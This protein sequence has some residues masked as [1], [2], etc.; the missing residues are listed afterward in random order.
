MKVWIWFI[1]TIIVIGGIVGAYYVNYLTN[2][3]SI[4]TEEEAREFV[5]NVINTNENFSDLKNRGDFELSLEGGNWTA[6]WG[7]GGSFGCVVIFDK[8]GNLHED[9]PICFAS[10]SSPSC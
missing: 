7:G 2:R 10:C 3:N 1:I 8:V 6:R 5:L 9:R 4:D